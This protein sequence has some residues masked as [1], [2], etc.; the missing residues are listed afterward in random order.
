[1]A[2]TPD[3]VA[4]VAERG[5]IMVEDPCPLL[6]NAAFAELQVQ[7]PIPLLVDGACRSFPMTRLFV[8]QHAKAFNLK[9][10]KA[11]GYTDN[12]QI[13][14]FAAEHGCDVNV[15]LF[16]ESSLEIGRASCRERGCKYV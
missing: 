8:E 2:E 6:P 10:Q 9:L 12:W 13:A 14:K 15:G 4:R 1:M 11:C 3:Y 7:C 5:A 16:G